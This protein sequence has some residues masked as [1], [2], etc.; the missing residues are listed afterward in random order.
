MHFPP[1]QEKKRFHVSQLQQ[2]Y[3][4][5]FIVGIK[6]IFYHCNGGL[7]KLHI[8]I[9]TIIISNYEGMKCNGIM[10]D[11]CVYAVVLMQSTVRLHGHL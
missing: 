2:R 6:T 11:Y 1:S 3:Q 9:L 5:S 10:F 4:F 8:E 7:I